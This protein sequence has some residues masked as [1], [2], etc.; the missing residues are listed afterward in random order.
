MNITAQALEAAN[1][2]PAASF[3][4]ELSQLQQQNPRQFSRVLARITNSINQAAQTASKIGDAQKAAQFSELAASLQ[5]AASAR[6][7]LSSS[8][9]A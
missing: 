4:N 3:L 1:V 5:T 9:T 6:T 7:I 2:S 8:A